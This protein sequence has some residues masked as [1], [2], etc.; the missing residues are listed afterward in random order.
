M[1]QNPTST[2]NFK[3]ALS[4]L[5]EVSQPD[6]GHLWKNNK[7]NLKIQNFYSSKD[8]A[9]NKTSYTQKIVFANHIPEKEPVPGIYKELPKFSKRTNTQWKNEQ[10][11]WTGTSSKTYRWQMSTGK[12]EHY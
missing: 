8:T 12:Y 6:K 9:K 11:I 10:K 3:K 2:P 4:K 5:R 7:L 1:W